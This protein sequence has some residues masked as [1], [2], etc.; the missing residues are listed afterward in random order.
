MTDAAYTDE[1]LKWRQEREASLRR[2][3]G[4]LALAGLFWLKPGPNLAGSDPGCDIALPPRLPAL[5]GSFDRDDD[6]VTWRPVT[7]RESGSPIGQ[8]PAVP[9]RSDATGDPNTV[10]LP[11]VRMILVH[12]GGRLGIRLWD[13][14]R[15]GRSS[16]PGRTWFPI[17]PGFRFLAEYQAYAE[18]QFAPVPDATGESVNLPIDGWLE[19]EHAGIL[20][21]LDATREDERSLSVHFWDPTALDS[22]YPSGRY[23]VVPL[24][25]AERAWVDFNYAYSPPCAFT[26][27]ATCAF[28]PAQNRLDF[29]IEAGETYIRH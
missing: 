12:R 24:G 2:D 15:P 18:P 29:R 6:S 14:L 7:A 26:P 8:A 23:L 25:E 3:N 28:A 10:D 22:T 13:N 20:R 19:F 16:F 11:G 21:R 17:E 27:F 5:V 4:W 9:L 1:V